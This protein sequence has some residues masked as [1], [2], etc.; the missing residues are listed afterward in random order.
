M[1]R[2]PPQTTAAITAE[3]RDHG[4]GRT[5]KRHEERSRSARRSAKILGIGAR[6]TLIR[7]D[8]EAGPLEEG[9]PHFGDFDGV[10]GNHEDDR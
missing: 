2:E 7:L 1:G 10:T 4:E 5:C 8:A 3:G 9:V 6:P